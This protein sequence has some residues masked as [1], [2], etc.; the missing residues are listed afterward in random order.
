MTVHSLTRD[1]AKLIPRDGCLLGSLADYDLTSAPCSRCG[2]VEGLAMAIANSCFELHVDCATREISISG[3]FDISTAPC[4]ATAIGRFQNAARG[5][6]TILLND[7]TFID[8]AGIG[9]VASASETQKRNGSR[10]DVRGV[11]AKVRRVFSLGNLTELLHA[12]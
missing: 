2:A 8:A 10:L 12:C 3:E 6:I 5:D 9:A 1:N 11:S 7:V 4:L